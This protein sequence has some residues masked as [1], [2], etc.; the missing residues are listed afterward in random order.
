VKEM[1]AKTI[2]QLLKNRIFLS[3]KKHVFI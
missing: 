3:P 2:K 1:T